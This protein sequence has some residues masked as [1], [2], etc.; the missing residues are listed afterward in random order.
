MSGPLRRWHNLWH[1]RGRLLPLALVAASALRAEPARSDCVEPEPAIVWSHPAQGETN[2]PTNTDLWVLPSGWRGPAR[3][4]LGGSELPAL[5]LS[6]GYDLGE[7]EPNTEHTLRVELRD[8]SPS[9]ELSFTTGGGPAAPDPGAAPGAVTASHAFELGLS[10]RCQ[11]ALNTQDCFDT[12]QNTYYA[13]TPTNRAVGW[14]VVSDSGFRP[15]NLWPGECGAP[16]LFGSDRVGPCATVYGIDPSGSP[17]PGERVCAVTPTYVTDVEIVPRLPPSQGNPGVVLPPLSENDTSNNAAAAIDAG[18][19]G[20]ARTP[21][22]SAG[23]SLAHARGAK[24][25]LWPVLLLGLVAS[26]R[27]GARRRRSDVL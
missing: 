4:W 9:F 19:N 6:G 15:I 11:A 25:A 18:L 26:C 8:D 2:V 14:V 27:S 24:A 1:T 7:L 12:G 20:S 3:V 17:H 5:E 16:L 10:S 21:S 23:C 22:S 13:F